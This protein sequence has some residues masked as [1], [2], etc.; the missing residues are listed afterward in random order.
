MVASYSPLGISAPWAT[1]LVAFLGTIAATALVFGLASAGRSHVNPLTLVLGG[2]ALSAVMSA[3]TSAFVLTNENNLDRM[4]FWTV[5]SLACRDINIVI[6]LLPFV[7]LGLILAFATGPQLNIRNLG[8]DM[9]TSLG[10]NTAAAR[11]SGMG[12]IALLTGA[13]TAAAGPLVSLG[14][15]CPI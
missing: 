12:I 13:T 15:C 7:M 3:N 11:L 10:I 4:H 14:G 5:G 9:A 8:D 6:S 2:A 1:A